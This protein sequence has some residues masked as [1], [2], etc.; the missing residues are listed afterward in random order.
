MKAST[1]KGHQGGP[2]ATPHSAVVIPHLAV[3]SLVSLNATE[4]CLA[5]IDSPSQDGALW[6]LRLMHDPKAWM[7]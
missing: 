4:A 7:D 1:Q 2:H 5:A 6:A 3:Q